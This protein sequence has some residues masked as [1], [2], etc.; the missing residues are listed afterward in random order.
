M[1]ANISRLHPNIVTA[2]VFCYNDTM[3][4]LYRPPTPAHLAEIAKRFGLPQSSSPHPA[5]GRV[6]TPLASGPFL[7]A[8][9][10]LVGQW[11]MIPPGATA[12]TPRTRNGAP[13]STNNARC[14][15]MASAWTYRGAWKAG[16]RCLIPALNFDEPNYESGRNVWFTLAPAKADAWFLAGLYD[17]WTDPKTGEIVPNYT[18]IT[19][20]CDGHPLL[21]R[22]HKPKPGFPPT[23][24]DKRT[25]VPVDGEHARIWL[26]GTLDQAMALIDVWPPEDFL[27]GP[28]QTMLPAQN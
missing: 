7:T 9:G 13:L 27:A 26:E 22:F 23:A 16:K 3:C 5:Y 6:I 15:R 4:N 24:Q 28:R 8:A 17:M 1:W 2:P 19:Q 11:G 18:M 20:N 14:E 21:A 25:V 10:V 12:R